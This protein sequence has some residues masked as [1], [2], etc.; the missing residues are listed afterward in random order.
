M[1]QQILPL[2]CC[3]YRTF[4]RDD[5]PTA[6]TAEQDQIIRQDSRDDQSLYQQVE[7]FV[8]LANVCRYGKVRLVLRKT[9]YGVESQSRSILEELTQDSVIK[10]SVMN[11]V[12]GGEENP[13]RGVIESH[14]MRT[15]Q[16]PSFPVEFDPSNQESKPEDKDG[17]DLSQVLITDF[18]WL[19]I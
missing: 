15:V 10:G 6:P 19:R 12:E 18:I 2:C 8:A 7:P 11:F 13:E 5:R 16:K 1:H 3:V 14:T 9:G 17:G 4:E